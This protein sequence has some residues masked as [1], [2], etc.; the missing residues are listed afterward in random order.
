[1][2]AIALAVLILAVSSIS[3]ALD[4]P[5]GVQDAYSDGGL[6][7]FLKADKDTY[8]VEGEVKLGVEVE[9]LL[10]RETLFCIWTG[11]L[12]LNVTPLGGFPKLVRYSAAFAAATGHEQLAPSDI[13]TIFRRDRY[14]Q[15]IY[16]CA[17]R[18]AAAELKS[19]VFDRPGSYLL[20]A[21]YTNRDLAFGDF[22]EG[23]FNKVSAD[24]VWTGSLASNIIEIK[25]ELQQ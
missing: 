22:N 14:Y 21:V 9:S 19:L 17:I 7:L 24:G 1:M 20:Q 12:V 5:K 4:E 18:E 8:V 16:P 10:D 11:R 15:R 6:G 2:K 13:V 3:Y 25:V 23:A